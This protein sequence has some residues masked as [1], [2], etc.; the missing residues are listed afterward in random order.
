MHAVTKRAS[1]SGLIALV[2]TATL[3]AGG[4]DRRLADAV[5][6]RDH[7]MVRVLLKARADVNGGQPDGAT[8]LQWAAHW[9]DLE[10]ADLLLRAGADANAANDLGVTPLA[11]ACENGNVAMI[12]VLLNHGA[13]A[14]A[15]WS[16]GETA[17][18]TA[19][20]AGSVGAVRVLVA[21]GADVN[22]KETARG[23]TPLMWAAAH[24]HAAVVKALI[25]AGADINAR[26]S[27]RNR[28]VHTGGRF[29]DRGSD[30]GALRMPLGGF[31]PLLFA[32]RVG[33]I[34]SASVLLD[35]GVKVEDVALDGASALAVAAL[36]GHGA[37]AAFLL[38]KGADPNAAGAGYTALHAAVLHGDHDLVK[39]LV[40]HGANPNARLTKGTPS[41]YYSK[42]YAFNV[43][44]LAGAT[45]FWLAARY[46][47]VE[48]LRILAAG[49]A[50]V[51][52]VLS[53]GTT[54]LMAAIAATSGFGVGNRRELYLSPADADA[55][56]AGED[57]RIT[58]ATA[59]AV[60]EL[61]V[62]V[63]TASETGDTALHVA[64]TQGVPTV[65]Q[66]LFD[67]GADLQA[68]NKR[69]LTPL[70]AAT[71]PRTRNLTGEIV[72][73]KR[74]GTAELLRKLGAKE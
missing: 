9:D 20:R 63:N 22:A 3:S 16:S 72:P 11:L 51:R 70:G 10:T 6:R 27:L 71:A 15:S 56:V 66:L 64:A 8:A 33:D 29:G 26:S 7:S 36:S 68:R 38:D 31:T 12:E 62:D 67:S 46:G 42:D 13:S 49:G 45:P 40:K 18:M 34:A 48:I 35:A 28:M 58:F 30:K 57:E 73:D 32:A 54:A 59:K 19:A 61:G 50:D 39:A 44:A 52:H 41:R 1:V 17:L 65:A 14:H 47:D 25:E 60:I 2:A 23:Q 55:K 21:H 43:V 53:D 5:E 4:A 24:A 69:G 74:I 37:F